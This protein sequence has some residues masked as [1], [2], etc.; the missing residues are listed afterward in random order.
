MGEVN[1]FEGIS[2]YVCDVGYKLT[3]GSKTRLCVDG[4]WQGTAPT[5]SGVMIL[6][7]YSII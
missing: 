1:I 5:C 7:F 2:K 3:N 6:E 4:S